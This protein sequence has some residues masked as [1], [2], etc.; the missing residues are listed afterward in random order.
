MLRKPNGSEDHSI[1]TA[2]ADSLVCYLCHKAAVYQGNFANGT[3]APIYPAEATSRSVGHAGIVSGLRTNTASDRECN[4]DG[5]NA[6]GKV[7][8]AR[9]V[10]ESP[11]TSF[12]DPAVM[13]SLTDGKYAG[14]GGGNIFGNK[15][16]NCHN[17]SDK[18]TFGGIHGNAGNASYT[19]YSAA[20]SWPTAGNTYVT[21]QRKPY[22]FLPG[23]GN[24]RYNGGNGDQWTIRS[25]YAGKG[26][27]RGCYTLNGTSSR[28]VAGVAGKA[29]IMPTRAVLSGANVATNA[30]GFVAGSADIATDNGILGS[31]G[32]C[33]DHAGNSYSGVSEPVARTILRPLTY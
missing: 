11:Y 25:L 12:A 33:S 5:N 28:P 14:N 23:L 4:P 9:L 16:A 20:A 21:V 18:K 8:L 31:W 24:F 29:N 13:Q 22:R 19:T 2:N 27:R 32:A 3:T 6:Q 10:S 1:G 26:E 30:T 17:A 7:G 15:C